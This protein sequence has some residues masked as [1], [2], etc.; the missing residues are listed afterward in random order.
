MN[1]QLIE[2]L[3]LDEK[4]SDKD[5]VTAVKALKAK[6]DAQN[7]KESGDREITEL[8]QK[9]GGALNRASAQMVIKDRKSHAA[10]QKKA[11]DDKAKEKK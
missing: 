6:A 10:R 2:I 9:S 5:I 11:E 1:E 8:V 4:A 7:V 3:G